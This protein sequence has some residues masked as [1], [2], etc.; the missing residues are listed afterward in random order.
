MLI[1]FMS[2]M[3]NC[4]WRVHLTYQTSLTCNRQNRKFTQTLQICQSVLKLTSYV[5][6]SI[7]VELCSLCT[8]WVNL[9]ITS[10]LSLSLIKH[11]Q[12]TLVL[13][14]LHLQLW[15]LPEKWA[16]LNCW[17]TLLKFINLNDHIS[18]ILNISI[19]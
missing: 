3:T 15:I 17:Y 14:Y 1:N 8:C 16:N 19:L 5:S 6:V 18:K 12:Q 7:S 2:I 10:W 11:L 13:T 4:W 9:Y